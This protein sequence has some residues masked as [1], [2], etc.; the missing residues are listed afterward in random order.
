MEFKFDNN[1]YNFEKVKRNSEW[2]FYQS[3]Y[4]FEN[5]S[6]AIKG[7]E[8]KLT[9]TIVIEGNETE[10]SFGKTIWAKYQK[11]DTSSVEYFK[12]ILSEIKGLTKEKIDEIFEEYHFKTKEDF[13]LH[14]KE[15]KKIKGI[16][17]RKLEL[18]KEKLEK[19]EEENKIAELAIAIDNYDYAVKIIEKCGSLLNFYETPYKWLNTLH[20][21]FEK[22][23]KIAREKLNISLDNK[24]RN[25]FLIAHKFNDF[26]KKSSNYIDLTEFKEYLLKEVK[27]LHKDID[28]YLN[29]NE[30]IVID[31]QKVYLA[32]IYKAE[33]ETPNLLMEFL[34]KEKIEDNTSNIIKFD[35]FVINFD[36]NNFMLDP[37]QKQAIKEIIFG[38]NISILTGG[39][40]TG[41]STVTKAIVEFLKE[42]NNYD[43][44][45][46]APTGKA[47]LRMAECIG[48][49]AIT[50]HTIIACVE[51]LEDDILEKRFSSFKKTVIIIDESSML[52]QK[53]LYDFLKSI[54]YLQKFCNFTKII[55]VGDQYQL[56]SIGSGQVFE[57]LINSKIFTHTHLTKTFRQA[58]GSKIINNANKVR[59]KK[60]IDFKKD[61]E[62]YI[63]TN[64][65]ENI[66]K[67]YFKFQEKYEKN[68]EFYK[69]FQIAVITNNVK[70]SINDMFKMPKIT[71]FNAKFQVGDKIINKKNNKELGIING[72]M[73]IVNHVTQKETTI[74]FYDNNYEITFK[75]KDLKNIDF[76]YACTV[77][78]LQG[79]EYKSV[80]FLLQDIPLCDHRLFYTA[81]TR[82]KENFILL[83]KSYNS[84][85][86]VSKKSNDY[87]RKTNFINRLKNTF[88]K[89][90]ILSETSRV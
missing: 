59:Y 44:M 51:Y 46:L 75:N 47:A 85:E 35:N 21:G 60:C 14:I 50:I 76:G 45:L 89:V 83:A 34:T 1:I 54:E 7:V 79:S 28:T 70:D 17:K 63:S 38:E 33:L 77:H 62:F 42:C 4:G 69:N 61:K 52:S 12:C 36:N 18:L 87:L 81:I 30:L 9:D 56:P 37:T 41:K 65:L 32:E 58:E 19:Q 84:I 40:G 3:Y 86:S 88:R 64:S 48:K 24:E 55:F 80:M 10:N 6:I 26:N 5:L 82:A 66:R 68:I 78:K 49:E 16:G 53:L 71:N 23:D 43:C 2:N 74:Y 15:N 39:A 13:I 57:D 67:I 31:G 11:V 25:T 27:Y 73:G 8:L 72:D 20:I 22:I 29:E 90:G